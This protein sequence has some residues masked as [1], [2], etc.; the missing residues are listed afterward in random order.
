MIDLILEKYFDETFVKADGFD[1]AIIGVD[2]ISMRL[3][4]S[5]KKILLNLVAQGMSLDEAIE[6]FEFNILGSYVGEQ[7]PIFCDDNMY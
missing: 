5:Q 1:D 7:T 2:L 3:I 4:Y 6:Y